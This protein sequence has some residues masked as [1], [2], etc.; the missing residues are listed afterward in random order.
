MG[1]TKRI[2]TLQLS[3]TGD[4]VFIRPGDVD[5]VVWQR[6]KSHWSADLVSEDDSGFAT[7]AVAFL[8]NMEW[9]RSGWTALGDEYEARPSPEVIELVQHEKSVVDLW[10]RSC[11]GELKSEEVSLSGLGLRRD[12]TSFQQRDLSNLVSM[13]AGANFSVPGA[14]KQRSR[15]RC[16]QGFGKMES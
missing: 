5:N 12:L 1:K 16:G 14:G 7:T 4:V 11:N 8:A 15:C 2:L 3:Q 13:R 10:Q 9:L 6:F